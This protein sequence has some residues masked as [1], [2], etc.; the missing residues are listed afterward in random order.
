MGNYQIFTWS[1]LTLRTS[2]LATMVFRSISNESM[3]FY[4]D[5]SSL[6]IICAIITQSCS[7]I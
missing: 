2:L 7:F 4:F 5:S 1:V 6:Y 3:W